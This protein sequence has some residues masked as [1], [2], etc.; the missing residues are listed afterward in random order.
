[1][2]PPQPTAPDRDNAGAPPGRI[3]APPRRRGGTGRKAAVQDNVA[4]IATARTKR[5][6]GAAE[7][8]HAP[9]A[10]GGGTPLRIPFGN[11][12]AALRL[13]AHYS[14]DGWY[15]PPGADLSRFRERG[16]L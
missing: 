11:K 4:G 7:A 2:D 16:W 9:G 6:G 13:G 1:M 15:A 8:I 14:A 3:D 10:L 5:P 12:E